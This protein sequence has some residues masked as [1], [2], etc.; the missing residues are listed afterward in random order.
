M[1]PLA[2]KRPV[3]RRVPKFSRAATR[4]HRLAWVAVAGSGAL[5]LSACGGV[6]NQSA[7]SGDAAGDCGDEIVIG[8]PYPLSGPLAEFGV[9]SLQGMQVAADEINA[10]GGIAPLNG[11]K[12]KVVQED[13]SSGDVAQAKSAATKSIKS[14]GAVALVGAWFSNMT[15]TVSTVA[16]AARVPLVTQSWADSL[17]ERKYEYYFQPP[18]KSSQIGG[19]ATTDVLAAAKAAGHKFT[20]VA[21]VGPNDTANTEQITTAVNAFKDAGATAKDPEFYQPGIADATPI[22]NRIVEQKPDLVLMSG[23]PADVTLI[24]KGLRARGVDAPILGFGG[25][26]VAPSL[27]KTLGDAVNGLMAVGAWNDD[28]PLD[29]V[30]QASAAYKKRFNAPFMPMEAGESWV[31]VHLIAEAMKQAQSCDPDKIASQL[32]Q[33]HATS[34]PASAMPGGEVSFEQDGTNPHAVPVLTQWV[35]GVP[36]TVWPKEY[37][38]VDLTLGSR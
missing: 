4:L 21:A 24:I 29:G 30:A 23:P 1:P 20:R 10:A 33:I 38:T 2:P 26:F 12:L 27:G 5:L 15:T 36:K 31:A 16:Q 28:L 7:S 32:H 35:D 8:A 22:V 3:P 14:D 37:A 17:S 34:G 13:T 25:A 9:N 6:A 19:A 18:P 11:A